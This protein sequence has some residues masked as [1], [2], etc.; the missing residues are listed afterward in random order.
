LKDDVG[1]AKKE[2]FQCMAQAEKNPIFWRLLFDIATAEGN[3][4]LARVAERRL[5]TL[6]PE[7]QRS[8]G[9]EAG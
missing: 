1:L 7:L 6:I 4:K 3:Q 9:G 8:S 2:L 5:K